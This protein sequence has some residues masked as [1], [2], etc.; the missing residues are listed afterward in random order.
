MNQSI[1][2]VFLTPTDS[3]CFFGPIPDNMR[4]AGDWMT[5]ADT[6]TSR[7]AF[8]MCFL[9]S[10]TKEIPT[11]LPFSIKTYKF[12]AQPSIHLT[13]YLIFWVKFDIMRQLMRKYLKGDAYLYL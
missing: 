12:I 2:Q 13:V 4:I 11:A 9:L 3:R 10:L 8:T 1:N 7:L 5:P 6:I